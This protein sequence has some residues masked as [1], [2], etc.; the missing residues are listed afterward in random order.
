MQARENGL[1]IVEVPIKINYNV[2]KPS[3]QNPIVHGLDVVLSIVKQMSIRRPLLF[4]GLP[5]ALAMMIAL[6]FWVWTIQTFTATRQI[7][8]NV[9]LIAVASTI[10]GLM[11]LITA[12]I[13]WVLISLIRE[14]K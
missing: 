8:T 11:L 6:F 1:K 2:E 10:I 7:I 9:A 3:T 14:T 4:Y 13:L 12:M 5:G